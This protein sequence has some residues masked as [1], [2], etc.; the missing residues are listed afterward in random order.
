MLLATRRKR[1]G[2][3]PHK[4]L[5]STS[6]T[7]QTFSPTRVHPERRWR[8]P[9]G[10]NHETTAGCG[11]QRNAGVDQDAAESLQEPRAKPVERTRR[12]D[13]H[14]VV[15]RLKLPVSIPTRLTANLTNTPCRSRHYPQLSHNYIHDLPT[16]PTARRTMRTE[17]DNSGTACEHE[18][19]RFHPELQQE[20]TRLGVGLRLRKRQNVSEGR[21]QSRSHLVPPGKPKSSWKYKE[22]AYCSNTIR[23][24]DHGTIRPRHALEKRANYG[25]PEQRLW[26]PCSGDAPPLPQ[27]VTA[28]ICGP[29]LRSS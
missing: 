3:G 13:F 5:A 10:V 18:T 12:F 7:Q 29:I 17:G 15:R 25:R 4:P 9:T 22:H 24:R 8:V 21:G 20:T 1:D 2:C 6:P 27:N 28:E 23:V 11:T 14:V 19:V 26:P 16:H